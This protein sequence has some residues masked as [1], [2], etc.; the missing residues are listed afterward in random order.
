MFQV[1]CGNKCRHVLVSMPNAI[2]LFTNL[3]EFYIFRR[4]ICISKT[5]E[6]NYHTFVYCL[7]WCKNPH[8]LATDR[9]N[10]SILKPA[11]RKNNSSN[12]SFVKV[13][14]SKIAARVE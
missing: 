14:I 4:N 13:S 2:Y 5:R 1:A 6:K 10:A 12:V 9:W 3:K 7:I 8:Y 11:K